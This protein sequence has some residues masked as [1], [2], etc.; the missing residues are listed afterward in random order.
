[1]DI[2]PVPQVWLNSREGDF[3]SFGAFWVGSEANAKYDAGPIVDGGT[4]I[5]KPDSWEKG[6]VDEIVVKRTGNND[7]FPSLKVGGQNKSIVMVRDPPPVTWTTK[8]VISER[9][10]RASSHGPNPGC[11]AGQVADCIYPTRP[12][13]LFVPGSRTITERRTSDP[14]HFGQTFGPDTPT[15][16]CV[17]M[18]QSTGACEVTQ[19]A[20]GRLMALE[21]YPEVRE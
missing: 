11:S 19:S 2:W 5:S 4:I 15:Q 16:V 21:R 18:T 1:V 14:S 3:L 9:L 20:E 7:I 13:G 12:G 10:M 17:T 6:K 8:P